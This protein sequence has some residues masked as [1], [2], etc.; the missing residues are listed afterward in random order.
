ML[1]PDSFEN[2]IGFD[3]LRSQLCDYCSCALGIENINAMRF[4]AN[5]NQVLSR[6]A[7][8]EE[9]VRLL[10]D[11]LL[12]FPDESYPDVRDELSRLAVDGVYLTCEQLVGVRR[13]LAAADNI[14][15]FFRNHASAPF[16]QLRVAVSQMA[17]VSRHLQ[18]IDRVIDPHGNILDT[19]SPELQDIRRALRQAQG[20]VSRL[21]TSILHEAQAQGWVER[22]VAPALRDGRLVI[23]IAPA[24]R[25]KL[26]G[27]VHDESATGKTVF[28]EPQ[29]VVEAN[30]RIRELE[31]DERRE[32]KRILTALCDTLRPDSEALTLWQL[33]L[34]KI[35]AWRAKARLAMDLGAIMPRIKNYP[36]IRWREARHPLLLQALRRQQRDIV[37]LNIT[38]DAEQRIL[39]ISG[40]NA[41]GKSVCLKTVA[42]LQYMLQMGL[43]VPLSPDSDMGLFDSIMLDIGDEQSIENDLSTYSSHLLNIKHFLR[44][45]NGRTLLL[46]DE[47][48]TGTEPQIGGAIAQAAL[49]RLNDTGAFGVITTHYN[50]LK[51]LAEDTEGLVNG[52][53]LYD[54]QRLEPL[55]T[56]EIGRPGNSFAIEI[57]RKIGLPEDL[58][59][60]A[61]NI[62]G[63]EYIDY[64]RHLHD[65]ARDK[66]YWEQKRQ[67]VHQREKD[68]EQRIA[69]YEELLAGIKAQRREAE[70]EARR[71]AMTI[72][73]DSRALIENTIREIREA[74]AD[75]E[76]TKVL[77]ARLAKQQRTLRKQNDGDDEEQ[78]ETVKQSNINLSVGDYVTRLGS[79][80]VGQ[81]IDVKGDKARVTFGEI[82]MTVP[83]A[84]LNTTT[85]PKNTIPNRKSTTNVYDDLR[86]RK[87]RFKEDIDI[88]GMRGEQALQ[89]V[90]Y[91][92]DDAIMLGATRLRILHGTGEG[93]LRQM[94]RQYLDTV[95]QVAKYHDEAVQIGGA[96]ITVVEMK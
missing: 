92:I 80:I 65:I 88:R 7:R 53:M 62:V 57:A 50:N 38:L 52:A 21:L 86:Q 25:R 87:L 83:I 75:K 84:Q 35:D 73:D 33:L 28:V 16:P 41:G 45:A 31:N 18:A 59:T 39:L 12:P 6:L 55:F 13:M 36:L 49:V 34:G 63:T 54:R 93:I 3:L 29:Q 48:G 76:A 60:A 67:Q 26:G 27:I 72:I 46:I 8:V 20:S 69:R 70:R 82:T 85:K 9:L 51:H 78:Q 23:P 19:A 22:D 15:A 61:A 90:M 24:H 1:Y 89:T 30:N 74:Q 40:P 71:Q 42:L 44:N 11:P 81:V 95:P 4:S 94:I 68:L 2:K 10:S 66:R 96:G 79:T 37:P 56:L 58:I 32:I 17:P 77:R 64:E 43:L 5:R 91:F 47:F 14:T